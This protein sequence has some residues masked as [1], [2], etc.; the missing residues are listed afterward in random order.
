VLP[1]KTRTV[2]SR[3]ARARGISQFLFFAAF[4]FLLLRTAIPGTLRGTQNDIRIPYPVRLFLEIDP[5][6]AVLNAL[7][8]GSLYRGLLWSLVVILP[9]LFL[10]R[11]FCGWVCPMGTVHHFFSWFKSEKKRGRQ[12]LESNR[13]RKWQ[14]VKYYVLAGVLAAALCGS[15]LGGV[16]DPISLLVRSLSVTVLPA[17]ENTTGLAFKPVYFRQGVV[18]GLVF[19]A[20]ILANFRVTRFW[21]RALCPL[22]GLLGLISRGSLLNLEKDSQSCDQC[23]RCLLACQGGD[24]PIP[25]VPWKKAECHLCFNCV[26]QCPTSGIDFRFAPATAGV[27][28]A[29]DLERRKLLAGIGAGLAATPVLRANTGMAVEHDARLIRP[30]GS[31]DE[32]HF[33]SRCIR[34]GACMKACPNNALHPAASEAGIEGF[35]TPVLVARVG[36]CE[37]SCSLCGQACPTGA[38]W[39]FT[40]REKAWAAG[41]A[42]PDVKPI[43]IGTAFY[44]RG[45]CLPWAMAKECIVCE[46]WCPTSPKAIYLR[47][48]EA[49]GGDNV[50]RT[51]RQPWVDPARCVGCGA[52]EYAC[53]VADQPA[54]YV[55]SIG[56]SR[57]KTNQILLERQGRRR[58]TKS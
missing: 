37:P 17:A 23:N 11:V 57:S 32:Q 14:N 39:E 15:A 29:P 13:Y 18:L 27:K 54:V 5:L 21:C 3:L 49:T 53:P 50:S 44:D 42:G 26:G 38:I 22:G 10:G 58:N 7:A 20:L 9:T 46:E 56:E 33:L 41:N 6:N 19:L 48:A 16:L 47:P 31:L 51:V 34:C 8:S 30:P 36:Y 2:P 12:L 45:R 1:S 35:W 4:V 25:G 40:A 28:R 43:R 55:T 24:D 52:C